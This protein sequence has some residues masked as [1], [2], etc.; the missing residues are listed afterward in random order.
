[1][2]TIP[3]GILLPSRAGVLQTPL[4]NASL[5][6]PF[7]NPIQS[8]P[9]QPPFSHKHALDERVRNEMGSVETITR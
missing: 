8:N 2:V 3:K 1:M 9:S 4:K 6:P 5:L 7:T